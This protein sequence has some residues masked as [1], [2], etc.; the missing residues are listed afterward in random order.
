MQLTTDELRAHAND[1]TRLKSSLVNLAVASANI[2]TSALSPIQGV[3]ELGSIHGRFLA[4]DPASAEH[5]LKEFAG[6][7][8]WFAENLSVQGSVF[9]M[10]ETFNSLGLERVSLGMVGENVP[11]RLMPQPVPNYQSLAYFP[12][13]VAPVGGI[14][15]MAQAVSA[16]NIPSIAAT[17]LRWAALGTSASKIS[18]ELANIARTLGTSHDADTTRIGAAKIAKAAASAGTFGARAGLMSTQVTAL[19]A[20]ATSMIPTTSIMAAVVNMIPHPVARIAADRTAVGITTARLQTMVTT[21][22]PNPT[23]LFAP[24]ITS[25]GQTFDAGVQEQLKANM[26]PDIEWPEKMMEAAQEG[27]LTPDMLRT[28]ARGLEPHPELGLS[29]SERDHVAQAMRSEAANLIRQ[30]GMA[31]GMS[32]EVGGAGAAGGGQGWKDFF[33]NLGANLIEELTGTSPAELMAGGTGAYGDPVDLQSAL[34]GL[35]PGFDGGADLGDIP[36]AA[37]AVGLAPADLAA[38]GGPGGFGAAAG[39]GLGATTPGLAGGGTGASMAQAATAPTSSG[40]AGFGAPMAPG[41]GA[42]GGANGAK[43]KSLRGFHSFETGSG[44]NSVSGIGSGGG[45]GGS[46]GVGVGSAGVALGAGVGTGLGASGLGMGGSGTAGATVVTPGAGTGSGAG[47]GARMGGPVMAPGGRGGQ[48]SPATGK[49][50]KSL[51]TEVEANP[52]RRAVI[53]DIPPAV[54]GVI[55][56]WARQ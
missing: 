7:L 53:G 32:G 12:P 27:R 13:V 36:T 33:G 50:V 6:Q 56:A 42:A 17:Q 5:A 40:L 21:S 37:N 22:L 14:S 29:A 2:M 31:N 48:A 18:S 49:G 25:A 38:L 26:V 52:N 43:S 24:N 34:H 9:D 1:L 11:F 51:V 46:G 35:A 3:S 55:G 30:T 20:Q 8:G 23:H 47:S 44:F 39:P 41:M 19:N 10:Q 4:Q 45:A 28:T 16:T 54:P 15:T